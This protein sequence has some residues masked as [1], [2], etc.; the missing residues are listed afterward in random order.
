[1]GNLFDVVIPTVGRPSLGALLDS[2]GS[3]LPESSR[4]F[5]V[6][7][8][9]PHPLTGATGPMPPFDDCRFAVLASL[10]RGPAAAR[11]A[12][13]RR[14]AAD[15]VVFLDDDVD[16]PL[17]W[18]RKLEQD[19]AAADDR[20][21]AVQ[22]NVEE[23]PVD[24]APSDWERD[25]HGLEGARWITADLAVRRSALEAVDGFDERFPRAYREDSDLALRLLDAGWRLEV[26]QRDSQH[27][28]RPASWWV[29]VTMQRGNADDVL[30]EH[31]HGRRWRDRLDVPPGTFATH[32]VT[33]AA[34]LTALL[35]AAVHRRRIAAIAGLL[36]LARTVRFAW[37]RTSPGPRTVREWATMAA[38]GV[39]IPPAAC[40]HRL[41]GHLRVA[42]QRP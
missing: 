10:K 13:W 40:L 5:V 37:V 16:V 39:L 38:T 4:V 2:L 25:V 22:G 27:S 24:R 18:A 28:V 41:R 33:V 9:R 30:I 35:A 29:S 34:G 7:N 14:S 26:G 15:W 8:R 17:E 36:W 1:M 12:G 23:P 6:D 32:R 31:L 11:N 3:S 19:L 20:V 21:A 42:R